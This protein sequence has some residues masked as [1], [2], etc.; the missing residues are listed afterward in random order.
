[1]VMEE[2]GKLLVGV[3]WLGCM[4]KRCGSWRRI[5]MMKSE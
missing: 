1:M 2:G 3:I 4:I 5:W